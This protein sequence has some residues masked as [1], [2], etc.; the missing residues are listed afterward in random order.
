[1]KGLVLMS[2]VT[3]VLCFGAN[4]A[5]AGNAKVQ[6]VDTQG[7]PPF[8]RKLVDAPVKDVAQLEATDVVKT[9][10]KRV[11]VSYQ[12]KPPYTRRTIEVPVQDI[13]QFEDASEPDSGASKK[14]S[15]PPYSR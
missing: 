7:K 9:V 15:R 6:V 11:V 10:K 5:E 14:G 12:G 4:A 13:A 3:S 1:M 2:V 8:K